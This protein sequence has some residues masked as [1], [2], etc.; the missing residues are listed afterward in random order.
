MRTSEL[1]EEQ[2]VKSRG[3]ADKTSVADVANYESLRRYRNR[4]P[5]SKKRW[6][7][8]LPVASSGDAFA[9]T[10]D[11]QVAPTAHAVEVH[12]SDVLHPVDDRLPVHER[13]HHVALGRKDRFEL[14]E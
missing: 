13:R 4:R 2:T 1:T 10:L 12:H 6:A 5:P 11:A 3:E 9:V 14:R 7:K 8:P